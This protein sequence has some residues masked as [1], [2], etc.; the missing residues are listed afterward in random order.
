MSVSIISCPG[1]KALLLSDTVIC[2]TCDRVLDD[3]RAADV[4]A[5][6]A[7]RDQE[8]ELAEIEEPC[9][10]CGVMV[11][12]GLVRCWKCGGFMRS[13]IEQ[14]FNE[15]RK[16]P[17]KIIFSDETEIVEFLPARLSDDQS[18]PELSEPLVAGDNDFEL[19][20]RVSE[21]TAGAAVPDMNTPTAESG[22]DVSSNVR[23]K[24]KKD[25]GSKS[26]RMTGAE[27]SPEKTDRLP[28]DDVNSARP[29]EGD[30]LLD[31]ALREE[32]EAEKRRRQR[33]RERLKNREAKGL[34]V[35]CPRGHC[36][37]VQVRHAGK[38]GRCPKCRQPFLVPFP[39]DETESED[40]APATE[41]ADVGIPWLYDLRFHE[42]D[43]EQ[44]KL[45]AGSLKEQ[46]EDVDAVFGEDG[47]RLAS[48]SQKKTG[49]FGGGGGKEA[50]RERLRE[51]LA[52]DRPLADLPVGW[53]EQISVDALRELKVVQPAPY[54]HESMF[55]GVPV[56]GEGII[57]VRLPQSEGSTSL[58]F[59]SF[60][61]SAYRR[62]VRMLEKEYR[63]EPPPTELG[64]P[65]ANEYAQVKC[66]FT[67]DVLRV[68]K[69]S[70]FYV[71]DPGSTTDLIAYRC[72]SCG[73][74]VS[75]DS[76]KKERIGGKAGK[77]LAK[78]KCPKCGGPFG[79]EP[80]YSLE[81]PAVDASQTEQS[82]AAGE[83]ATGS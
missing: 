10:G 5:A 65:M 50:A 71:A 82:E 49:L 79:R 23:G 18:P 57:A 62:F 30:V 8:L 34:L 4:S 64:I 25:S 60:G 36:I 7:A 15:L 76:R 66:H 16:T 2:P 33:G 46:F 12:H 13:D 52:Q 29:A 42:I 37:E 20:G 80:L 1:C 48:V 38:T 69:D 61:I 45:K 74:V 27:K 47:M 53:H 72:T 24:P 31:V 28:T 75:E 32:Q 83:N 77:T 6:A 44:L 51:H 56:F 9:H 41:P 58:R 35:Y 26:V 3:E 40:T 19:T 78:A 43:P 67:E 17:Q 22:S 55:A 68:I 63:I 14:R 39:E 73:L 11:R 54:T 81:E 21:S 59:L 70:D